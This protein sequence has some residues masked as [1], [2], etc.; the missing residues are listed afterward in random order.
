MKRTEGHLER[1][2]D[3]LRENAVLYW[4]S[5]L[6]Q[7]GDSSVPLLVSTQENFL[8]LLASADSNPFSWESA[9][10]SSSLS[11]NLFLKHLMI[12]TDVGGERVMRFAATMIDLFPD[13]KFKFIWNGSQYE[14]KFSTTQ[15]KWTNPALKLTNSGLKT[16]MMLMPETKDLINLLLFAGL[17]IDPM[18]P[19]EM[20]EKCVVGGLIGHR[21]ELDTEA[22]QKYLHVSRISGGANANAL[23]QAA[24][25]YVKNFLSRKLTNWDFSNSKIPGV[26]QN[27]GRTDTS[28]DIVSKS[29]TGNYCAIEVSFQVTT[30]STIERKSGQAVARKDLLNQAGHKVAYVLDGAGNFQR[31]SAMSNIIENSDCSVTFADIE[32]TRLADYIRGLG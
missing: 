10:S 23:G 6:V 17:S 28:F 2:I 18:L 3:D 29:P 16:P 30:N 19:I 25:N 26:S 11:A 13:N 1:T 8:S 32:L 5:G 31:S 21:S 20:E 15:P 22:K 24:E 7:S 9:L 14:Y 4:P 12:F 27:L